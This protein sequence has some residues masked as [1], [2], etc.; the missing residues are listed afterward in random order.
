[1]KKQYVITDFPKGEEVYHLS[2]TT[3]KMV[4]IGANEETNEIT[5]RW[6]DKEGKTHKEEFFVEELAK[7]SDRGSGIRISSGGNRSNYW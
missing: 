4:S 1:M 6:T 7:Y 2:N 3:L 5:C